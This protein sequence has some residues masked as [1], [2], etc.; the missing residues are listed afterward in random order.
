M[1]SVFNPINPGYFWSQGFIFPTGWLE[2]T[3]HVRAQFRAS[4]LSRVVLAELTTENGGASV[5]DDTVSLHLLDEQSDGWSVE[6]I[7]TSL[8]VI[9]GGV[10]IPIGQIIQVPVVWLPTRGTAYPSAAVPPPP[11]MALKLLPTSGASIKLGVAPGIP[12]KPGPPGPPDDGSFR[13]DLDGMDD[14]SLLFA[15]GLV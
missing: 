15:N 8:T 5:S 1:A 7:V 11:S 10:E 2:P 6:S 14:L 4:P 3:D 13:A 9:R 12:G